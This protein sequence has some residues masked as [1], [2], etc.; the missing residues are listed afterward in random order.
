MRWPFNSRGMQ[1]ARTTPTSTLFLAQAQQISLVCI[2]HIC[3][4]SIKLAFDSIRL[5]CSGNFVS[6]PLATITSF[7]EHISDR[8][9]NTVLHSTTAFT[10]QRYRHFRQSPHASLPQLS[11]VYRNP[12]TLITQSDFVFN[13]S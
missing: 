2:N 4:S 9:L 8:T 7:S 5:R 3:A 6:S 13:R 10:T 1:L 11:F 12:S